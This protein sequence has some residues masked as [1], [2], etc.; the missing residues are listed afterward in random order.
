MFVIM[1][2]NYPIAVAESEVKA[3]EYAIYKQQEYDE[4]IGMLKTYVH[5]K[6]VLKIG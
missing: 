6:E 5:I 3:Q 1:S 4:D 2:N